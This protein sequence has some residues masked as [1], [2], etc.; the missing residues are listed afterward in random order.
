MQNSCRKKAFIWGSRKSLFADNDTSQ[1]QHKPSVV[2][3]TPEPS[4]H[5]AL[6]RKM[7]VFNTVSV[8]C[9]LL[10]P[11]AKSRE[12]FATEQKASQCYLRPP[13]SGLVL[14][15]AECRGERPTPHWKRW[16]CYWNPAESSVQSAYLSR[17]LSLLPC[18]SGIPFFFSLLLHPK[19]TET[20]LAY[21]RLHRW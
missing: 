2:I 17:L 5:T 16:V 13:S 15:A 10:V 19:T 6:S 7:I 11:R 20:L 1:S 12:G 18:L 9:L 21:P 8:I 14:V 3:S 4:K